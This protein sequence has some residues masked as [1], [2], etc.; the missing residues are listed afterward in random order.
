[1]QGQRQHSEALKMALGSILAPVRVR[2]CRAPVND[3]N[4]FFD[5]IETPFTA[6]SLHVFTRK[7]IH[8]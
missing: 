2:S 4:L 1:M 6:C 3:S 5:V 7:R 8:P